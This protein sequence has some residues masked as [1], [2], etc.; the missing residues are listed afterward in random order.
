MWY[1]VCNMKN[2]CIHSSQLWQ[3][4][5]KGYTH[6]AKGHSIALVRNKYIIVFTL[7][8]MVICG[9]LG[10]VKTPQQASVGSTYLTTVSWVTCAADHCARKKK[11]PQHT[12]SGTILQATIIVGWSLQKNYFKQ[13]PAKIKFNYPWNSKSLGMNTQM[14]KGQNLIIL[15]EILNCYNFETM[16]IIKGL[17]M[18][19]IWKGLQRFKLVQGH[20]LCINK[21]DVEYWKHTS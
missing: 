8:Y 3:P 6:F 12:A 5:C 20:N 21:L 10:W 15:V 17:N 1:H 11:S 18:L 14:S 2:A 9:L 16:L 4:M 19:V 13:Y 7:Q